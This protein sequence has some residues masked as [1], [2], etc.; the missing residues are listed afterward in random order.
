MDKSCSCAVNPNLY[1]RQKWTHYILFDASQGVEV[2]IGV[3]TC[4][5]RFSLIL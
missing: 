5:R 4:Q 3:N 2:F 1:L